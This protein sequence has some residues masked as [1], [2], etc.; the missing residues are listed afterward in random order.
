MP[1]LPRRSLFINLFP[2]AHHQAVCG[3]QRLDRTLPP[4]ERLRLGHAARIGSRQ[5]PHTG[6]DDLRVL[7]RMGAREIQ[8]IKDGG[9][10]R[11]AGNQ[12]RREEQK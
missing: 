9:V 1:N 8:L 6:I 5:V 3:L 10:V 2:S 12:R 7:L 11:C 4:E